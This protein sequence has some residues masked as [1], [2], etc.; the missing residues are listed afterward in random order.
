MLATTYSSVGRD[1]DAL[2]EFDRALRIY[3]EDTASLYNAGFV[4]QRRGQSAQA[5]GLFRRVTDIDPA[6]FPAWINLAAVHN[7]NG[8][9]EAALA[10]AD[11][12]VRA[13][14]DVPNAYL[15]RG[16]AL[17][18][19]RRFA[20]AEKAF[21]TAVR[22]APGMPDA[23]LGLGATA[24]DAGDFATATQ[25]F[26]GLVAVAPSADAY[27]GLVH[28]YRQTGR[29]EDAARTAAAARQRFPTDPFFASGG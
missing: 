26:E 20:E 7:A 22:L 6:F 24:I 19:L 25:A 9:H 23:L 1:D 5:V 15:V 11:A 8:G 16:S 4:Y 13:R 17:R 12:A 27:R 2:R 14:P 29:A 28:S 18:G 21:E 3:P 10:A